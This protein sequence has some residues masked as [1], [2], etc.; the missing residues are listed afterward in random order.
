MV[1]K[2]TR[3]TGPVPP[4]SET[5]HGCWGFPLAVC[6][7]IMPGWDH[8]WNVFVGQ[9]RN[10]ERINGPDSCLPA[11]FWECKTLQPS[12]QLL[13]FPLTRFLLLLSQC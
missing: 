10:L 9:K 2:T 12:Q 6:E 11:E 13:K 4:F 3:R 7:G 1:G 5:E 8:A